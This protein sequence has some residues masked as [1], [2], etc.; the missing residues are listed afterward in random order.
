MGGLADP[1]LP[2]PTARI[3]ELKGKLAARTQNGKPKPGYKTNVAAIRRE[4]AR[5]NGA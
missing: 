5:L 3:A 4:I 2:N 1:G